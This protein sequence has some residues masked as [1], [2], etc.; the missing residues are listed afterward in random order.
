MSPSS[1]NIVA[2]AQSPV[3]KVSVLVIE[4]AVA[5]VTH[6]YFPLPPGIVNDQPSVIACPVRVLASNVYTEF[7]DPG[8]VIPE[9]LALLL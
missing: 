8:F 7:P 6:T 1:A 2:V 4:E 5:V 3:T 9:P